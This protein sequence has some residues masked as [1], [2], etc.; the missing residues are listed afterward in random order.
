MYFAIRRSK[1]GQYWF[2]IVGDNHETIAHSELYTRQASAEKSI[3]TIKR[4]AG[5]A[6]T[7]DSTDDTSERDDW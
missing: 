4:G 2:R 3:E 7:I 1:T 5:T 6:N